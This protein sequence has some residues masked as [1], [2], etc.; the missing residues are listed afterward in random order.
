MPRTIE[1]I[2]ACHQAA[3][4]LRAAGKPIW[5]RRVDIRSIIQEDQSNES[6]E[7]IADISTRIA[8]TLRSHL[9]KSYFDITSAD[10][11]P[12]LEETVETMETCTVESLIEDKKLLNIDPVKNFNYWLEAIYDWADYNRIWLGA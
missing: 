5:N 2:V 9:P 11:D 6:P 7:H 4:G 1:H 3:E 8:K 10:Y 12:D